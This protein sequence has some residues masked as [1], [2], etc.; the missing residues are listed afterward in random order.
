M[1]SP[2]PALVTAILIGNFCT[3][4]ALAVLNAG[5]E[6]GVV[7]RTA[8]APDNL[9]LG[10][11]YGAHAELTFESTFAI[12]AYYLHS[13][14]AL[15]STPSELD[16]NARF[17]TLGVRGRLMLPMPGRTKP[18]FLIGLGH[19]WVTYRALGSPGVNGQSWEAPIG[20]GIAHQVM[21]L[22]QLSVEGS[23]RPSFS[24]SGDA[25][26]PMGVRHPDGGWA[27][28]AGLALDF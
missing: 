5:L 23:Y 11:A 21:K 10:F 12:G 3:Q 2:K 19:N 24:F 15:A 7:K 20:F 9:N 16:A 26:T 22:F 8:A 4:H 6:A 27:A 18:Y 28:L 17:E 13:T 1:G 14:N 25:Y